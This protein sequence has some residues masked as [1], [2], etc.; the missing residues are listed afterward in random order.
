[1]GGLITA[2]GC[3]LGGWICDRGNRQIAYVVFGLLQALCCVAMAYCPHT[4]I[5]YIVWTSLYAFTLGLAYA[6]FSAFVFE[7]IGRGAAATK[8]TVYASLSNAP[9]YYMTIVDGWA[10]THYGSSGMLNTEAV[11][12]VFGI[13][14]FLGLLKYANREKVA[15][16]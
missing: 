14:L 15:M 3:L 10:Q 8:F 2:G 5:M 16:A 12:A 9:I 4:E 7:A 11:F 1:M 13:V 6:G